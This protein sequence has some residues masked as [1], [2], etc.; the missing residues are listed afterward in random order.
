MQWLK[1]LVQDTLY[2]D[3]G[4][5]SRSP[6]EQLR[7]V[8][9]LLEIR[10]ILSH[11]Q[12]IPP[13]FLGKALGRASGM[14]RMLTHNDSGLALF[15]NTLEGERDI[16]QRCLLLA[17]EGMELRDEA[18]DSGFQRL[19]TGELCLIMDSGAPNHE[20]NC[21]FSGT[22]SFELTSRGERLVVNCGAYRGP[23]PQWGKAVKSSAAHSTLS[24][25]SLALETPHDESAQVRYLRNDTADA[26]SLEAE[27][28][29]YLAATGYVY[30]RELTL[31]RDALSLKGV[32]RLKAVRE[33]TPPQDA[34]LRFH[35]HPSIQA[36]KQGS[37][38]IVRLILPSGQEWWFE[39]E[40]S[41]KVHVEESIYLGQHGQ[42]E[43]TRQIVVELKCEAT[44]AV[45]G[46]RFH[47]GRPA[48]D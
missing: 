44:G 29:G 33:A 46:W 20:E 31:R 38:P 35:L 26:L 12:K 27:Y 30:Q 16:I 14:L 17:S 19:E 2:T 22:L 39:A 43:P 7:T 25:G 36:E 47:R 28:D 1:L 18:A 23:Q 32:D 3:G 11:N 15:N 9:T 45:Q 10:A 37:A 41:P 21:T 48:G 42:P 40:K 34:V 13:E 24:L 5:I 6:L 4:H 8:R